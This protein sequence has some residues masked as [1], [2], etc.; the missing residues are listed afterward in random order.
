MVCSTWGSIVRCTILNPP[1]A[2]EDLFSA[3]YVREVQQHFNIDGDAGSIPP[4]T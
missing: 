2:N 4:T 1:E 3:R